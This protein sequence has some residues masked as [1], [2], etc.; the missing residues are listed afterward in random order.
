ML[1][2]GGGISE[3]FA[4]K[5][6]EASPLSLPIMPCRPLT[7]AAGPNYYVPSGVLVPVAVA[8]VA[9]VGANVTIAPQ[10]DARL[11]TAMVQASYAAMESSIAV[12]R[13]AASI[14]GV[15]TPPFRLP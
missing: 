6:K 13:P 8:A 12:R 11:T 15:P 2:S 10:A 5:A 9:V 1:S 7:H 3:A 4:K 14:F